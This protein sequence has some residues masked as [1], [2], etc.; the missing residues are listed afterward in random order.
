M[1]FRKCFELIAFSALVLAV[2]C[3]H[4]QQP[5]DKKDPEKAPTTKKFTNS[6]E[7]R[8]GDLQKRY[9]DFTFDYP[10]T[11]KVVP[12][13]K[14]NEPN[15][16][17]I[18]RSIPGTA[19]G[20]NYT[21][22]NFAVGSLEFQGGKNL[23]PLLATQLSGQFA[24]GF[25]AYKK[26]SEGETTIAGIKGYEFRFTSLIEKTPK[27]PITIW[28]RC[29]MLMPENTGGKGVTIFMLATNLASEYKS[30]KDL[31]EKGEMPVIL[32]SL[33]IGK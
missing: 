11:W 22:E 25:P 4:A 9:V 6:P 2:D 15:Y 10:G 21:L 1:N 33:K 31:G 28:G 8:T 5:G 18:E 29:V 20:E 32:K 27:G 12:P 30:E 26:T 14:E 23:M 24:K 16:V 3:V 19:E 7:G 17:K 13:A